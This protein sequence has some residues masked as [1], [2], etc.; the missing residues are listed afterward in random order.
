MKGGGEVNVNDLTAQINA[1]GVAI[2]VY[3]E[4]LKNCTEDKK[5]IYV[6]TIYK[7]QHKQLEIANQITAE[8]GIPVLQETEEETFSSKLIV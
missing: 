5:S 3:M 8:L 1:A 4:A 2:N 7:L 6:R